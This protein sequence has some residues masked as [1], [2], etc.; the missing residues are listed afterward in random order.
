MT[1]PARLPLLQLHLKNYLVNTFDSAD[2]WY[3][4]AGLLG[5]TD[6]MEGN[7]RLLRSLRFGD[8]DYGQRIGEILRDVAK[9]DPDL[10]ER[11]ADHVGLAEHLR[12]H[13][14]KAY[15]QLYGAAGAALAAAKT[16]GLNS[17]FDVNQEV[18]RIQRALHDDPEQALGSAKELVEAVLKKIL[19]EHGDTNLN[20]DMPKLIKRVQ[21]KLDLDPAAVAPTDPGADAI[22]RM[23]SGIGQIVHNLAELRNQYGTGHG[24]P[25]PTGLEDRHAQLAVTVA[26]AAAAFLMETHLMQKQRAASAGP[27]I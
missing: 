3:D 14:A 1:A 24:K 16:S 13:D 11:I 2:Q 12:E 7:E 18:V 25:G 9:R 6:I 15:G 27:L 10:V 5:F 17:A 8:N 4:L 19:V 21:G 22:K 23:L 26:G 20:D